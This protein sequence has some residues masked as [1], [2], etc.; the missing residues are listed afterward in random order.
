MLN[1]LFSIAPMMDY[2]D[3]HCRYFLRLITNRALLYTE[4]VT[5][6]AILYGPSEKLL[7]Y[8]TAEHPIA[9]QIGGSHPN[10]LSDCAKIAEAYQYDEINL[11]V[12]CPSD[13]VQSGRFGACLMAEPALVGECVNAMQRAV[14]IP[15]T[16]KTRIG[17]DQQDSYE[18][19]CSFIKIV[20]QAGCQTFIIHARKAWLKGLSPKENREIPPLRYDIVYQLK[21]DFPHLEIII[22]G[23]ILTLEQ[24]K[25]Q[26]QQVDG[27]MLGRAAYHNP[28]M[29]AEV[30]QTIYTTEKA[31]PTREAVLLE[32][33][34][35]I[36]HQLDKN[37][38]SL[39]QMIRPLL[40]LYLGQPG[41][42]KWRRYLS[43]TVARNPE[44][45]TQL[46]QMAKQAT[47]W[48]TLPSN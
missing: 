18:E 19:L 15:I 34:D 20:S 43:E 26:L 25:E 38:S 48:D 4:M 14:H 1:R 46:K 11:N 36:E 8:N 6:G 28:Y 47:C 16:V 32:Y 37:N 29:L 44:S 24:A 21:H 17:I 7:Q 40:G 35:Y 2:T 41:G 23:G 13:R 39:N 30:D 10:L 22:N 12:G 9:L 27:V 33:L 45:I 42:K 5:M 31:I 3:R